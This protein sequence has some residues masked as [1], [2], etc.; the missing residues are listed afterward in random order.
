MPD[1]TIDDL[2]LIV[3]RNFDSAASQSILIAMETVDARENTRVVLAYLKNARG[4][5]ENLLS[6]FDNALGYWRD[7]ISVADYSLA[8]KK[9]SRMQRM[10]DDENKKS[11]TMTGNNTRRG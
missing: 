8:S 1:V 5:M 10:P 3:R 2:K 11:T 6:E 4:D 9:W 7:T